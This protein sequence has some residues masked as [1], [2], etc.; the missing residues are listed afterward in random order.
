M[1]TPD[2]IPPLNGLRSFIAAAKHESFTQAAKEMHVTPGAVN[3][4]VRQLEDALDTQLFERSG[5]AIKL[6][7][8]GIMYYRRIQEAFQLISSAT[9]SLHSRNERSLL[10]IN[11][12]STFA[13]RWLMP[14]LP[15]LQEAHPTLLVDISTK[16][17]KVAYER[18]RIDLAIVYADI[19]INN[20][21][22][23]FLMAEEI[24]VVCSPAILL[25]KAI[26]KPFDLIHHRLIHN[27]TRPETWREYFSAY[28]VPLDC[29]QQASTVFE[30]FFMV[31][32]AAVGAMG[33]A[34]LPLYLVQSELACGK[35]MQ[36]LKQT[37]KPQKAYFIE[38]PSSAET[39]KMRDFKE[40]LLQQTSSG[41]A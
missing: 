3:R 24:G 10:R 6:T 20:P 13:L 38:Y 19:E 37:L 40:W 5:R 17:G 8:N 22:R 26:R 35:L 7:S 12:P 21:K 18:E 11:A 28:S 2:D 27:S 39:K 30:H 41:N 32:E 16:D 34:I 14:K 33:V 15:S 31:I 23:T 9:L 1:A 36:P 25:K 4:L 29:L